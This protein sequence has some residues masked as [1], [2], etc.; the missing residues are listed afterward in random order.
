MTPGTN[1]SFGA[2]QQVDAGV[3]NV[4]YADAGP[5]DGPAVVLLHGW[6]L[7]GV[8]SD[9]KRVVPY[10]RRYGTMTRYPP[11]A[12]NGVTSAKL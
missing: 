7:R 1:P 9:R 4:G 11:A 2:L 3:L 5:P 12:S 6:P 8:P 10:P